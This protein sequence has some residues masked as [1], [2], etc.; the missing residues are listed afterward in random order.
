MALTDLSGVREWPLTL[1]QPKRLGGGCLGPVDGSEI[2]RLPV[3]VGIAYP[4]IYRGL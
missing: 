2:W 1:G 4:S 3:E